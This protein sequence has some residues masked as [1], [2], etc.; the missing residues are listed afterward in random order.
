MVK[1]DHSL[2]ELDRQ[3]ESLTLGQ[4]VGYSPWFCWYPA[5]KKVYSLDEWC[6]PRISKM[7]KI[8]KCR[9]CIL[10]WCL[11]NINGDNMRIYICIY[12]CTYKRGLTLL[13]CLARDHSATK[14]KNNMGM[15]QIYMC[16][17]IYICVCMGCLCKTFGVSC[18][19]NVMN[20]NTSLVYSVI[21]QQK[22]A[23][24][25]IYI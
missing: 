5:N 3:V 6:Q 22:L 10:N 14:Q 11:T 17:Y 21:E 12:I 23:S 24:I 8:Y 13:A 16:K 2:A 18:R 7:L 19:D 9:H 4:V 1:Y 25:C 20:G 15:L